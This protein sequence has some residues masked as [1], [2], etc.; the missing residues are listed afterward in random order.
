MQFTGLETTTISILGS[1]I[2]GAVVR[3]WMGRSFVSK[4]ACASSKKSC[5][6]VHEVAQRIV[7]SRVQGIEDDLKALAHKTGVDQ[8]KIFRMLRALIVYSEIPKDKQQEI[9]NDKGE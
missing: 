4:D 3:V 9:L 5:G 8:A 2:T 1:M 6:Q 7:D